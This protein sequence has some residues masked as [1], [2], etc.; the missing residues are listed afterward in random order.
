MSTLSITLPDET[1]RFLESEARLRN[2]G[3]PAAYAG[4][5]LHE[6]RMR[7]AAELVEDK[8]LAGLASGPGSRFN[9][10]WAAQTKERV[11]GSASHA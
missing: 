10:D 5:L 7:S 8:L 2:A 6:A 9:D 1:M 4:K 3:S 11:F